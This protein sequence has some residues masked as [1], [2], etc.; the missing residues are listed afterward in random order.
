MNRREL[1]HAI[2]AACDVAGDNELVIVGSQSILGAF[3]AA[4]EELLRSREVDAYPKNRPEA[5]DLIDALLG[6]LSTF[7]H[8]HGF[9]VHGVDPA[10]ARLPAG[11]EER[12]VAVCS[13]DTHGNT[14]WCLEP[15]DL[16][17]SK[18]IV[19]RSKD[20]DYVAGMARHSLIRL[21]ELQTRIA[22]MDLTSAEREFLDQRLAYI[23]A[24]SA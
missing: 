15:H 24:T 17:A 11:W 19:P 1:E 9:Y 23:A 6:E 16:A 20:L 18:L 8:T 2:R 13:A 5:A 22:S 10:T 4:P 3:P 21:H 12:S 7:H 14:G